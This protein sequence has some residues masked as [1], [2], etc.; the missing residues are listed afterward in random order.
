MKL[1]RT[2]LDFW[3]KRN[4][5]SADPNS[6][7]DEVAEWLHAEEEEY[8][9]EEIPMQLAPKIQRIAHEGTSVLEVERDPSVRCQIWEYPPT[10]K[11]K[12]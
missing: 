6:E 2:T 1:K 5:E 3:Y 9:E 11:I 7:I 4:D 10:N 12:L 8:H